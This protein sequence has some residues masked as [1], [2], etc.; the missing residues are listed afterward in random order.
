GRRLI[1]DARGVASAVV[2]CSVL[3]CASARG[4][5]PAAD[6]EFWAF[7]AP[8][9]PRSNASAAA[10]DSQLDVLV[11]GFIVLDSATFRPTALYTDTAMRNNPGNRRRMAL[12]TSYHGTRFHPETIR[13]LGSDSTALGQAAGRTATLLGTAGYRG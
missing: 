8:W 7:S 13:A 11:S 3:A 4:R 2:A 1:R 12:V 9:D 10:H 5:P 6:A